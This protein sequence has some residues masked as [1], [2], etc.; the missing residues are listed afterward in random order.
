LSGF[1]G[2]LVAFEKLAGKIIIISLPKYGHQKKN[3]FLYSK[4]EK[5]GSKNKK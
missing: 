3:V 5:S 1:W 2:A 4:S